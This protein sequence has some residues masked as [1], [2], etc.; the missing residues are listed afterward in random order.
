MEDC[1][2]SFTV[3]VAKFELCI[4]RVTFDN[5]VLPLNLINHSVVKKISA[6]TATS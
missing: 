3:Y 2:I 4:E 6:I 1:Y 5:I